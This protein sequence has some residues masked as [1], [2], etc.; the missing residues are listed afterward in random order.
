MNNM[1]FGLFLLI[2]ADCFIFLI[3][4]RL[5]QILFAIPCFIIILF[6]YLIYL[7]TLL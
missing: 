3:F 5:K 6:L 1:L 7:G 2:I 4:Y